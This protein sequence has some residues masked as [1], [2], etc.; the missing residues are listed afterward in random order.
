MVTILEIF[1]KVCCVNFDF[2]ELYV[3]V[4]PMFRRALPF[5]V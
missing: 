1:S 3:D 5:S 4:F 2:R